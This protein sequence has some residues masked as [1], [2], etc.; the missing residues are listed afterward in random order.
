MTYFPATAVALQ[1]IESSYDMVMILNLGTEI[2]TN[3]QCA[4]GSLD[5]HPF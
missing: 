2:L 5:I 4:C 3:A 1:S